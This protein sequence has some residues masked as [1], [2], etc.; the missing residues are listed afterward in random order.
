MNKLLLYPV[1]TFCLLLAFET[2]YA[3]KPGTS[4][5]TPY[6]KPKPKKKEGPS[7]N[8]ELGGG[9]MGS[10]I[11]L[12]RNINE[13]NDAF[14]ATFIANYGGG[15]DKLIRYS[16]QYTKYFPIDIA[17]TWY[18]VQ[19]Q[20]FESNVE[21]MVYFKN[22]KTILYPFA[23]VSYNTF[24]G[25]FTGA[26]D[27]LNLHKQYGFNQ[28]VSN[29]WFGVNIGTGAEHSFGPVVIFVD[30]KMR[31]GRLEGGASF[32]IMD[33]CYSGGIRVK[34][35][36]PPAHIALRKLYRGINDKYHWF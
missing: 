31:V 30:Y 6:K 33:V 27:Y 36:V 9:I 23:G 16:I 13:K 3:Q 26:N 2:T 11:Y 24:K 20:T 1:L 34:L 25:F 28:T 15:Q 12:S 8:I 32:T 21:M 14:G 17:P 7:T 10:V 19:A 29:H 35:S 5:V 18:N 4:I 22:Q